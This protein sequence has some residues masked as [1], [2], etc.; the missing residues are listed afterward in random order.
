M[1]PA[2]RPDLRTR[3]L[4]LR[5]GLR[6]RAVEAGSENPQLVLLIPGWGC[7]VY[8]FREN[9]LPLAEAGYHAVA[10]D[11]KGHGLSDKPTAPEEYR[12]ESMRAHVEEIIEALGGSAIVCG[13]SM[14]AALGAHVAAHLPERVRSL[15][16]VSPVG[17]SGVRGLTP[18]RIAT[19]SFFSPALPRITGRWT[20]QLL[21]EIVNGKLREITERDVDEYW[22]PMQFPEFVIATRH[23]LHEFTWHA[24]FEPLQIP[25]LVITGGHDRMVSRRSVRNY[26][27]TMPGVKHID[28]RDAG[29]VVYDEAAPVVNDAILEFLEGN[30]KTA[31]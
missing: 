15:V 26:C 21:L 4:T 16:M 22:A 10:V 27:E 6:V 31:G 19:P 28:I 7:S 18:I 24:P 13:L 1:F 8:V 25:S 11:L 3:Y 2:G 9:F 5:S 20:I 29:H 17:F 14:G 12:L 30:V 23:L